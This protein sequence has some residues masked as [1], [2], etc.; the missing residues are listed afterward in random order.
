MYN[1]VI[2]IKKNA[3]IRYHSDSAVPTSW[4]GS[5]HASNKVSEEGRTV[6]STSA[7]PHVHDITEN[8][9]V[10]LKQSF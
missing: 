3:T 9:A 7:S 2:T 5:R 1:T 6:V 4:I 10:L 8:L